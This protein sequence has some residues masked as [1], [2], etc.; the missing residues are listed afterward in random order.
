[1]RKHTKVL[2]RWLRP[3]GIAKAMRIGKRCHLFSCFATLAFARVE[4]ERF[5]QHAL[6]QEHRL[7]PTPWCKKITFGSHL[8]SDF[9]QRFERKEES[10]S[11]WF[12]HQKLARNCIPQTHHDTT[13]ADR[14]ALFSFSGQVFNWK[15]ILHS[16]SGM[17]VP[18]FSVKDER[19]CSRVMGG[20]CLR[21]QRRQQQGGPCR[22]LHFQVRGLKTK[23]N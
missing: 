15:W 2:L 22:P 20:G 19:L 5:G 3:K 18:L 13:E 9:F 1:M 10:L 7:W 6:K 11:Q 4:N 17:P 14:H 23:T 16:V 21:Q 12:L 8:G